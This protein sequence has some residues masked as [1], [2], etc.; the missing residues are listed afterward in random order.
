MFELLK[1]LVTFRIFN[2]E[3]PV[4]SFLKRLER[5]NFMLPLHE[6]S[7]V[8]FHLDRIHSFTGLPEY[9]IPKIKMLHKLSCFETR[10]R[11][12]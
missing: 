8:W 6:I 5:D 2:E 12:L 4:K 10:F 9:A 1:T 7:V 11:L 3:M